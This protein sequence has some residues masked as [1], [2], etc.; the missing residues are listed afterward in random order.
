MNNFLSTENAARI[1]NAAYVLA[2]AIV[3]V[4]ASIAVWNLTLASENRAL[5]LEF[6]LHANNQASILQQTIDDN[7]DKLYAMRALFDSSDQAVTRQ[8]FERFSG[9][10]L[11]GHPAMLSMSWFPRVKREERIAHE[12]AA[13]RDRVPDYHIRTVAPDGSVSVAPERDEYFPNSY[14]TGTSPVYGLDLNDEGPRGRTL[15]HIWE[16]NVLSVSPPVLLYSELGDRRGY[17][18]GLPIYARGLPH[19]TIEQRRNNLLGMIQGVFVIRAM[20]DAAFAN[21]KSPVRRYLFAP[22]A[23]ADELPVYFE[24]GFGAGS[25]KARSQAELAA[26]LHQSYPIKFG[27]IRWTLVV[28]PEPTG[29]MSFQHKG[30]WIALLCGLLLSA[31]ATSFIWVSGRHAGKIESRNLRFDAALNN[32]ALGLLMYD[33]E[34]HLI[35]SNRRFA[36]MY[37]VPWET[38]EAAALGKTVAEAMQLADSL[39]NAHVTDPAQLLAELQVIRDRR[40][41]GSI[42]FERSDG[43]TFSSTA[44]PMVDGGF[45]VTFEDITDARQQQELISHLA[46]HDALTDLPNRVFFYDRMDQFL[47]HNQR[48]GAIA[49]LSLDLDHF[50]SVNDMFGHPIGDKLL[51]EAA[52]R[53]RG[54]IREADIVARLGGD[55]FAIVQTGILQPEETTSLAT[56]LIDALSAPYHL[57]GHQVMVGACIGIAMAPDDGVTPDQL[58]KNADLALCRCKADGGSTYRYFEP[59]M[60]ARMQERRS[61]ELDLRKALVNG[62]FT[63]NYQPVVNIKTG[64]VSAC[65]ALIRWHRPGHGLVPP[66]QFIPIAESTGLIVPIG[67]W[68]LRRACADAVEWPDQVTVAVNVST[69]QFKSGNFVDTVANA[70][71]AAQL[72]ARR[73]E[74]E[75]TESVLMEDRNEVLAMLHRIKHLGARIAMDDFGTGYSSLSYLRSFPFDKIKIDQSFIGGM[76]KKKDGLAILRAIVGLGR[77]VGIVTTAEGVETRKQLEILRSEGCTEAQG[78]LFSKPRPVAE[79]G[80]LIASINGQVTQIA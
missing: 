68:V 74:L 62:E 67:E 20:V 39:T 44:A 56:R 55:E 79:L 12:L 38:W 48:S 30:S 46:H 57:D 15:R 50:K 3:G 19:E 72:P 32:M 66:L 28:T 45:V 73:L 4:A 27:D 25:I 76:S 7:W 8:A 2:T 37:G 36:D 6:S 71:S 34:G 51:Q 61:I 35:I 69:I 16:Q 58:M 33:R 43:R 26:G 75:I 60:D 59:Q 22:D 47:V 1:R 41:T 18:A 9:S 21:V 78:Y 11:A 49:V 31:A 13:V 40:K 29:V 70:L 52:R 54:C 17:W 80:E 24:S 23:S 53:M 64:R 14:S 63:L 10:L 5:D 65:E 42:V 77:S